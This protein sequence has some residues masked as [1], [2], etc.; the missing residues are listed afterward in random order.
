MATDVTL[1]WR[2]S[3]FF[4]MAWRNKDTNA[5][6]VGPHYRFL[7]DGFGG[8]IRAINGALECGVGNAAADSRRAHYQQYCTLIGVTGCDQLLAC[9]PM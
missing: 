1:S 9:P 5:L 4:W 7:H 8:S 3:M 2:G 6:L